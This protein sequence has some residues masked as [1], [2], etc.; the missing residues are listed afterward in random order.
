MISGWLGAGDGGHLVVRLCPDLVSAAAGVLAAQGEDAGG[1]GDVPAH[2]REFEALADDGFAAGFDGAGADEHAVIA[3]VGIAHA[4]GVGFEVGQRFVG[5]AGEVTGQPE[6]G[7]FGD[8]GFDVAGVEV[9]QP[10]GQPVGV[11]LA[12]GG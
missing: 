2:A 7:G 5:V 8:E 11:P 10:G 6:A 12:E 3:E 1:A 4:V 9:G